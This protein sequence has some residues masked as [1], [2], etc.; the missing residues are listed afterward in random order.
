MSLASRRQRD[1][2][3]V[4][5]TTPPEVGGVDESRSA[6]GELAHKTV[7]KSSSLS[8]LVG[9]SRGEIR[10]GGPTSDIRIPSRPQ[11]DSIPPITSA[12]PE[13][14]GVDECR[15]ARVKLAHKDVRS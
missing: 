6:Q 1:S 8:C 10:R 13:V 7:R 12:S 3:P 5:N 2:K 15:A 9:V 4:L 11:R 14:G